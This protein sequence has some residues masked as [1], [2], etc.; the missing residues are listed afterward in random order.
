M[1][2][3]ILQCMYVRAIESCQKTTRIELELWSRCHVREVTRLNVGFIHR[4]K[5]A[6]K[7]RQIDRHFDDV[8]QP[9][10]RCP[11]HGSDVF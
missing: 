4:S 9:R 10:T 3:P 7:I 1:E 5:V 6:G 2:A 11:K 8:L